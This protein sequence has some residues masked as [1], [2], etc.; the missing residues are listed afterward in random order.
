MAQAIRLTQNQLPTAINVMMKAFHDDP[1]VA[2]LAPDEV[3]R[4]HL[5]PAF[6]GIVVNYCFLYG[7]V[8]TTPT[9]SGVACWLVPNK[10]SP[11]FWGMLRTGMFTVPLKFG[12]A[13]FQRFNDVVTYTDAIHK[14]AV[15]EPHWYLW[16][17]GVD[18]A[19]QGQGI[20]GDL[21]RPV[22]GTADAAGQPCYVETQNDS[23]LP[24]Y[25]R[26]GFE[27]V[28]DGRTPGG[29]PVWAMLRKP[30]R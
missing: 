19:H 22:L 3:K 6:L 26:H 8:W 23:N 14:Q 29:L 16:G 9:I 5:L 7:E 17:I 25:H 20:G 24:F 12:W 21:I 1:F 11:T 4:T 13:G 18:P 27:I 10:T 15:A 2:Y 28:S 30:Q